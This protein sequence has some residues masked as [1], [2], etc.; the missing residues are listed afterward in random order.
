MEWHSNSFHSGT[1]NW[2]SEQ[3]LK[4]TFCVLDG[5]RTSGRRWFDV[6]CLFVVCS[7]LVISNLNL[8]FIKAGVCDSWS[9][10]K[11]IQYFTSTAFSDPYND[12]GWF[13]C[14][15]VRLCGPPPVRVIILFIEISGQISGPSIGSITVVGSA[16]GCQWSG[17]SAIQA[18]SSLAKLWR[19]SRSI[20]S[21]TNACYC[22]RA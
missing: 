19:L 10:I 4:P 20:F 22:W 18:I 21:S 15:F 14:I 16:E 1:T 17:E 6:S 2:E 12:L 3:Q 13:T 5:G 8:A 7:L 11:I 9:W